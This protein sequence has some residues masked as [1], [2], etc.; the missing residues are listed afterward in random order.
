MRRTGDHRFI[1]ASDLVLALCTGLNG[2]ETMGARPVDGP[3]IAKLDMED[4]NV[5]AATPIAAVES[6]RAD[7]V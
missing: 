6:V 3:V 4:G 5:L 2:L 7:D 1:T